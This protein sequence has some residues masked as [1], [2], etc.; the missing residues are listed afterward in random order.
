MKVIKEAWLLQ[1]VSFPMEFM[2]TQN[3]STP[4][5]Y[6]SEKSAATSSKYHAD[7]NTNGVVTYKPVKAFL[8]I[9]GEE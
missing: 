6:A 4:K 8:I 1:H 9:E 3:T 2:F 5:L 7:I